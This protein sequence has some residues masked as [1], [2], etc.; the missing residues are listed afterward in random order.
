MTTTHTPPPVPGC[1]TDEDHDRILDAIDAVDGLALWYRAISADARR[2]LEDLCDH[3]GDEHDR[4]EAAY[5][6]LTARRTAVAVALDHVTRRAS[7]GGAGG[8]S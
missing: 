3:T 2:A 5:R 8:D 4:L 1:C 7:G 6:R